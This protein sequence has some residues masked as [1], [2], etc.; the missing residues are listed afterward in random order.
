MRSRACASSS[1]AARLT[2]PSSAMARVEALD[3]RRQRA[4]A[5][6][7]LQRLRQRRDVGMRF[8]ELLGELLLG[9]RR[10]L[11]L[12]LHVE[13]LRARGLQLL[14]G[15]EARLLRRAQIGAERFQLV[16]RRGQR[17]F[18]L[19]AR[20]QLLRERRLDRRPVDGGALAG[21]LREQR[22]LLLALPR[23]PRARRSSS[24]RR[25]RQL[26]SAKSAS[27]AARS[28]TRTRSRPRASATSA[29]LRAWRAVSRCASSSCSRDCRSA[30]S[31]DD[32]VALRLRLRRCAPRRR[33]IPAS[34]CARRCCAASAACRNCRSSSSRS[35]TRRC[36]EPTARPSA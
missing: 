35:W 34:I 10:R 31:R 3:L 22:A 24:A 26:R 21:Q 12:Q 13:D 11:L 20:G 14:V 29:S 18:R 25:S 36:C 6:P 32:G 23:D 4:R 1:S 17:L 27:C 16:A 8:G 5:A 28:A 9:E 15:G 33:P 30:I 19:A 7:R 2:A